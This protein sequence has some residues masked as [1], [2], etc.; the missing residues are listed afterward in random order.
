[1]ASNPKFSYCCEICGLEGLS[2]DEF[3]I[4]THT[5]HVDG[6]AV[7]PFCE[8]SSVSLNE[9]ILHVNQVHLDFLTPESEQTISFIDDPSPRYKIF[10]KGKIKS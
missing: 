1:M 4:H 6:N 9:L 3:R 8:L 10:I 2:E 7:C 5:A